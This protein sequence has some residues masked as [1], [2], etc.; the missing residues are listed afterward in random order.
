MSVEIRCVVQC[1]DILG[2]TPIWCDRT[3]RLWWVDV[4]R[5]AVQSYDPADGR[6]TAVRLPADLLVGSIGLREQG[7]LVM[8]TN[9]GVW[10]FDPES[11]KPAEFLVNPEVGKPVNRLNDGKCDRRGRFWVG[12]MSDARDGSKSGTL[13]R[14]DADHRIEPML[15]DF[16]LPNS[17]SWSPDDRTMYFADTHHQVIWAFDYDLDDG[18]I[19]N[20]R[21]FKDWSHQ[22]GRPD[23]SAVDAEGYLWNCMVL[24]GEVVRLAPNGEVDCV[25][26]MPVTNPTCPAFGGERLDTLYVTSHSQR[27][28]PEV[29]AAEPCAGG[30]FAIEVGVQ[31]LPEPRY[32]G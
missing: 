10:F 8:G 7:G 22:K 30:V 6:H 11:G 26:K 28:A 16:V 21:V 31:G 25:I 23:G 32:R 15:A 2:E 13:Y 17:L 24:T 4:R 18:A 20:R 19:S 9:Q 29:L 12:S 5:P 14:L 3:K 1:A 27:L